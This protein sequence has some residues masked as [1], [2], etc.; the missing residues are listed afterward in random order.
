MQMNQCTL[1]AAITFVNQVCPL[2]NAQLTSSGQTLLMLAASMSSINLAKAILGCKP[3]VK[4]RDSIG[5]SPLHYSA[6]VGCI[7]IFELL[8]NSGCDP[9]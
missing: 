1:Q 8:I 7:E 2:I 9:L 5:R 3:N 6:A 4:M